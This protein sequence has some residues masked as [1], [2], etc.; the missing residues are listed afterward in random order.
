MAA[1]LGHGRTTTAPRPMPRTPLCVYALA[2]A[3]GRRYCLLGCVPVPVNCGAVRSE[4]HSGLK[5][6]EETISGAYFTASTASETHECCHIS[7]PR[8][9][10]GSSCCTKPYHGQL[11]EWRFS[12]TGTA[13][14]QFSPAPWVRKWKQRQT[15]QSDRG[16]FGC[17]GR[18]SAM[19]RPF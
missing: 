3:T 12:G 17:C 8:L 1:A 14:L 5:I 18:G 11:V 4:G 6:A 10:D 2:L 9:R 19:P 15:R 13:R 7:R 16:G